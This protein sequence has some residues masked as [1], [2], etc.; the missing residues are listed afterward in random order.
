MLSTI[1]II[2]ATALCLFVVGK[3]CT[4]RQQALLASVCRA[5]AFI[6]IALAIPV[7]LALEDSPAIIILLGAITTGILSLVIEEGV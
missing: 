4:P 6:C 7:E 2:I 1:F 5:I 3:G